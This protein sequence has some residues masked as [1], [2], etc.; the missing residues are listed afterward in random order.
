MRKILDKPYNIFLLSIPVILLLGLTNNHK[1]IDIN[2]HDTMFVIGPGSITI[3]MIV[4]FTFISLIYWL[5]IKFKRKLYDWLTVMHLV[6]TLIGV[7][8]ILLW[9]FIFSEKNDILFVDLLHQNKI[10]TIIFMLI[11]LAQLVFLINIVFA[12]FRK[13]EMRKIV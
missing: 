1:A 11:I 6:F 13:N 2:I 4:P 12:I 7:L 3:L 9:P 8:T 5:M 10:L